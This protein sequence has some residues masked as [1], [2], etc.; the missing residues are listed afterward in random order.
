MANVTEP[1]ELKLKRYEELHRFAKNSFELERQRFFAAESKV[2]RYVAFL[3][4]VL[5]VGTVI[6]IGEF[7]TALKDLSGATAE[8]W[9]FV[10]SYGIFYVT[11]V[12]ALFAFLEPCP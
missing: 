9:S 10:I 2:E 11:S 8:Q 4:L 1:D 5:G 12:L 3:V 6:G 7:S